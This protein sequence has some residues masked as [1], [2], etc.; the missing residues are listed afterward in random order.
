[1]I[2]LYYWIN[3]YSYNMYMDSNNFTCNGNVALL[4][5][6]YPWTTWLW[7]DNTRLFGLGVVND[8]MFRCKL[9]G[10]NLEEKFE[11]PKISD[12]PPNIDVGFWFDWIVL[13][14]VWRWWLPKKRLLLIAQQLRFARKTN[15]N[16][17]ISFL[18]LLIWGYKRNELS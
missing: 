12:W 15:V 10:D 5:P 6:T 13:V 18:R 3:N 16:K 14:L 2:K 9:I 8:P 11:V 1:M 17:L 7:M 4:L